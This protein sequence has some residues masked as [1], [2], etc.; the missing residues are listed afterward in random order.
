MAA[1]TSRTIAC[2]FQG[3]WNSYQGVEARFIRNNG[4]LIMTT[5]HT[6]GPWLIGNNGKQGKKSP[7]FRI[8]RT[9]PDQP[10]GEDFRN[11]GYACI[12]PH[13]EGEANA[14]LIAAAPEMLDALIKAEAWV[15]QYHD[16]PG[17]DAA[18]RSMS[19]LLRKVI[20]KADG[21]P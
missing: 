21:Q 15:A 9:D 10:Q 18:S 14:R 20:A 19:A 2:R 7:T 8:W 16:T 5:K 11:R 13:V 6:P 4:G 1:D 3:Y 17:H 12:A